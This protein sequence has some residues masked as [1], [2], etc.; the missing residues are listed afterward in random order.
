MSV[1]LRMLTYENYGNCL[2]LSNGVVTAFVTVDV[3]PRIIWFGFNGGENLLCTDLDRDTSIEDPSLEEAYGDGSVYHFYGGHRLWT[4]P[5]DDIKSHYPDNDPV[6]WEQTE[7]GAVF[8]PPR[9]RHNHVQHQ[10]ELSFGIGA[11]LQILH[12]I[13]NVGKEAQTFAPWAI[14][15]MAPGGV[16]IIPQAAAETGLLANRV[17]PVWPYTNLADSRVYFGDRYITLQQDPF[18]HRAFKIGTNNEAGWAVYLNQSI[19]FIKKFAP[20]QA[21]GIYPDFGVNFETYTGNYFLEL[22]SLGEL[23]EVQPGATVTHEEQWDLK[24]IGMLPCARNE[25]SVDTLVSFLI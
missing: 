4:S 11:T 25:S 12:R 14:T 13:T 1:Q 7:T 23:C 17:M 5:E 15:Q 2:S 9:Q 16:A 22:E 8:T 24:L 3:G 21:N 18:N 20:W 19:A 10:M 6:K